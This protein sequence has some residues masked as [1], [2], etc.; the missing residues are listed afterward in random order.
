M[1]PPRRRTSP[2]VSAYCIA[3]TLLTLLG[4]TAC[5]QEKPSATGSAAGAPH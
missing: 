1:R 4:G 3:L 2:A 5:T